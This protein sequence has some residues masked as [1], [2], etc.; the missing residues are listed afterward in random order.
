MSSSSPDKFEPEYAIEQSNLALCVISDQGELRYRDPPTV[1]NQGKRGPV[2]F[3]S[4]VAQAEEAFRLFLCNSSPYDA[5]A[6]IFVSDKSLGKWLIP[7]EPN[8]WHNI[9]CDSLFKFQES[10][11]RQSK[12]FEPTAFEIR[13]QYLSKVVEGLDQSKL[14]P[15]LV[16]HPS[17]EDGP[18]FVLP[19]DDVMQSK[20]E[21]TEDIEFLTFFILF[22]PP[23]P[24]MIIPPIQTVP[25]SGPEP[26][27]ASALASSPSSPSSESGSASS[28]G[29]ISQMSADEI[30]EELTEYKDSR[31]LLPARLIPGYWGKLPVEDFCRRYELPE[32]IPSVL[33]RMKIK[34][35]HSLSRVYLR[36]LRDN[37][38]AA[39]FINMLRLA[40]IRFSSESRP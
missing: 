33:T 36:E 2:V 27:P 20:F 38:L 3:T 30:Q 24:S 34:D 14:V 13:F 4:F 40:V 1:N 16:R 5:S 37:G 18:G 12:I 9:A 10:Y 11:G 21:V 15:V 28:S 8:V 23:T 17:P 26:G 31:F 6:D 22:Y 29:S 39:Q 7:R 32:E 35:A 19:S 25:I